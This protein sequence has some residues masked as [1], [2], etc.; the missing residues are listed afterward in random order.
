MAADTAGT[1]RCPRCKGT[2][3]VLLL[4]YAGNLLVWRA[5]QCCDWCGGSGRLPA[6]APE[7]HVPRT[8]GGP[9]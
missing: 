6:T 4:C 9:Q 1:C 5:Q 7:Y 8:T 3:T 2:G